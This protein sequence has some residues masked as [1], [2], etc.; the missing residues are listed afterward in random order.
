M[1]IITCPTGM[2]AVN[3]YFITQDSKKE[4]IIIDPGG[5]FD[6]IMEI[7]QENNLV[8]KHVLLTHGHFD[9]IGALND[10]RREYFID[11][12][13]HENASRA[14][15]DPVVN[16]SANAGLSSQSI[17]CE[18]AEHIVEDDDE[19][20]LCGLTIKAIYAP[21][22]SEGS[23]VYII[24]NSVFSGDVI[25]RQS[26]GRTDFL[27]GSARKMGQSIKKLKSILKPE[28]KIY[29]GHF[30]STTFAE[31]LRTNPY[32]SKFYD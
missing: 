10:M 9:H 29:P 21:G 16:L 13:A 32:L 19:F 31:E 14:L 4:C 22:H 6:R 20:T 17:V 15:G 25:F 27:G 30:A 3:T 24:G 26:I 18:K 11:V 28:M 1:N 12:Y 2:L 23:M 7:V 5:S 8:P